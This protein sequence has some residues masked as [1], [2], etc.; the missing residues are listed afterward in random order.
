MNKLKEKIYELL[1][2]KEFKNNI[3][4]IYKLPSKKTIN[5]LIG[6][7]Y[8]FNQTVKENGIYAIGAVVSK[9]AEKDIEYARVIMRRLMWSLNDE[10]GGI[11]WGAPLAM[12]EIM[13]QHAKL[14]EEYHKIL[15]SYILEDRNPIEF[16][17]LR[18]E[19][20][21]GLKRLNQV[22]PELLCEIAHLL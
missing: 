19:V 4:A 20:I 10:S 16:G 6:F 17:K 7:L 5:A 9:V 21:L 12:A 11:G 22:H 13:V 15:I 8:H 3:D 1:K 2:E 18:E 14:A